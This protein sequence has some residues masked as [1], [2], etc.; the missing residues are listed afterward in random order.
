MHIRYLTIGVPREHRAESID[1]C[2]A[3]RIARELPL[4]ILPRRAALF[5]V[6]SKHLAGIR[7]DEVQLRAS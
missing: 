2:I 7:I 4:T 1:E 5:V 3:Q 6:A